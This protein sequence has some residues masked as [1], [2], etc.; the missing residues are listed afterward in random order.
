M[1]LVKQIFWSWEYFNEFLLRPW[2]LISALIPMEDSPRFVHSTALQNGG[3]CPGYKTGKLTS[4]QSGT[5]Y[6]LSA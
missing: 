2:K 5:S 1:K 6:S 3:M 4:L